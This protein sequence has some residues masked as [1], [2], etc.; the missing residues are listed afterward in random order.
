MTTHLLQ[1]YVDLHGA[2]HL[3][4][5]LY[6]RA[7]KGRQG[8]TLEYADS[9]LRHPE[10]FALEPG[11]ALGR[12]PHH[13]TEGRALFGAI[14]DSAPDR[15]GRALIAR[16]ERLRA[17]EERR[18]PRA[19][20]EIDY[21][22]G[23]HD[24]ARPGALRFRATEDGPFLAEGAADRMPALVQLP[25]L[26]AAAAHA[27][28]DSI[29]GVEMRLLLAPGSSLGGARPK[30]SVRE[31]DGSLAIAKFPSTSDAYNV[32]RW[33][34]VAL[35][36]AQKAGVS[37]PAWRLERIGPRDVLVLTRF[38]R[39]GRMRI[40]FLSAMSMLGAAD[41][42]AR[43]YLE[44]ADA[45]R[46]HGAA[47][48][49]DLPQLWRRVVLNVLISNTD[50][51]LRNLGFLYAGAAGWC[52]APAYDLNPVPTD[53]KPRILSTAIGIDGDLSASLESA[54]SVAR[55][56]NVKPP[57]ARQIAAEVGA[58][59]TQWRLEGKRLGAGREE[60]DRMASAFEHDDLRL[61]LAP[62][63]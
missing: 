19:L 34:A 2:T 54:L 8:A 41:R 52:L 25:A 53:V 57:E 60:L 31:K 23:V 42:D 24:E 49:T 1:V 33:E 16:A 15:W 21:L 5:R 37:I 46:Q 45:L 11:L 48:A 17:Q 51:H 56:F 26:L 18:T 30:A 36:I 29:V 61:A 20:L 40:P 50:D 22:L 35:G 4:G 59:V 44:I 55:A 6:A 10:R 63:A 62:R 47:T 9:W 43:S 27:E 3:V 7:S 39:D 32:V 28:D 38:D 58:A 13:T 12:A 14:G